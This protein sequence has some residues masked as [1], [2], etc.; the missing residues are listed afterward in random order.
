[1]FRL[2]SA[3][4]DV[5]GCDDPRSTGPAVLRVA[6]PSREGRLPRHARKCPENTELRAILAI[7]PSRAHRIK[8]R[9]MF[10]R[11]I[12]RYDAG[13]Q[14]GADVLPSFT[15]MRSNALDTPDF[16]GLRINTEWRPTT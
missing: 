6:H 5:D 2:R 13:A 12:G 15:G 1:M 11:P 3:V 8:K 4:G 14:C 10:R 7:L 16:R 9:R